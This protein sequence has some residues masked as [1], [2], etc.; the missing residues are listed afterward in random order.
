MKIK[1]KMAKLSQL[2]HRCLC[3]AVPQIFAILMY[4]KPV[5]AHM[6]GNIEITVVQFTS[7]SVIEIFPD[8]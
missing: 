1:H 2:W 3:I 5:S 6:D 8:L 4:S 7:I